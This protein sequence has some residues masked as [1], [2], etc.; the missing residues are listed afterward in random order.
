MNLQ[1]LFKVSDD[2]ATSLGHT[3][4][5]IDH[6]S[7][8]LLEVDSIVELFNTMNIDTNKLHSRVM[9]FLK[10]TEYP[11][12]PAS[13]SANGTNSSSLLVNRVFNELSKKSVIEQLKR[14]DFTIDSYF[15]LFE[16]LSF[17]NTALEAALKEEGVSRTE[18]A[19]ALQKHVAKIDSSINLQS[20][21]EDPNS[22]DKKATAGQM[23]AI[24]QKTLEDF[25]VNL[26]KLAQEGKLDPMIGRQKELQSLIEVMAR[27][28]KKNAI[29]TGDAGVGK[30][31]I[32]DGFAQAIA[33]GDVPDYLKG[34]EVLSLNVSAVTA[35]T[36]Y[37][38][39]F[40]ERM[41]G[42]IKE[43]K[44]RENVILF[45]DEVH[46]M[47][48]AGGSSTGSMDMSNIMKPALSRGDI[49]VIGATTYEEYRQNIEKDAAFSRRFTKIDVV[50]PSINET[51]EII[52]GLKGTYEKYHNVTFSTETINSIIN[53]SSK[54]LQ[55]KKFPDKAIDLMDSAAAKI[56]SEK[57]SDLKVTVRDIE[58]VVSR[59]TNLDISVI[60]C[61]ES[62][63]MNNL[64]DVL[65][66]RVFGQDEA[67]EKLVDNVMVARAGLR[68]K[69]SVQGA[70]MFVGPSG[71]GKT[72][73]T[74]AL[75]EAM[76][77][78]LIRFD[79]SEFS[80]DHT[81]SKLIGSPPGYVGHE[82]GNGQLLD[83]VEQFPN[84][85]LLLDEIEKAHPKV[86]LTFLQVL[87]EGRLTGSQG[88]TV[89]FNNIT[90]I[91]TTNL[92]AADSNKRSIGVSTVDSAQEKA[93]KAFLPPEF[94]N[95]IDSIVKFNELSPEAIDSVI[96]KFMG[97]LREQVKER[98]VE[99]VLT[100]RAREY[101]AEN[102]V[103]N[104]MGA[105]PMKR[106]IEQC[107]RVPLAKEMLLGSLVNGGKV[108][109]DVIDGKI[110]I[111]QKVKKSTKEI[112]SAELEA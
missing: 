3:Y 100:K 32:V 102:G 104:G 47:M 99:V 31:Q 5:T 45:I 27:K 33:D 74:K 26:T 80:Q 16:C 83:K 111:K 37:R 50:E 79:M 68:D 39:E 51:R 71:T 93:I 82:T 64:P 88:K 67:I 63:R 19:R 105:R 61:T 9:N 91:M 40:E 90:V 75:A 101:L 17:P 108:T 54:F 110:A 14:D 22:S 69:S 21:A 28:N 29:L 48:G 85:V 56:R 30:T 84:A 86:L 107:I 25:T 38:G 13:M 77:S 52:N 24:K 65:R 59:I 76:G 4:L 94:I 6:I 53:L 98:G 44:K 106:L 92:G 95:R 23:N 89:Y 97:T 73:I 8:T 10:S 11:N 70:F 81:V 46:I 66:S 42:I 36:K 58:E 35:G 55:N 20:I 112:D 96:D 109:F 1:K 57:R 78:E 15:V 43:L 60:S 41:E 72:E 12:Q 18:A 49:R 103:Q 87:D 7:A 2:L 62:E 34:V